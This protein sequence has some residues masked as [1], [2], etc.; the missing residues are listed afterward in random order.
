MYRFKQPRRKRPEKWEPFKIQLSI[1]TSTGNQQYLIYNKS[2]TTLYQGDATKEII[3]L[4]KPDFKGFFFCRYNPQTTK[5]EIGSPAP[6]QD[7]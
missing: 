2:Q 3:A 6:W 7:W 1:Y 5:I 4:L